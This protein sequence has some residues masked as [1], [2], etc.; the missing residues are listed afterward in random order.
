M[1]EPQAPRALKIDFEDYA[2][3]FAHG[4]YVMSYATQTEVRVRVIRLDDGDGP[5]GWGEVVRRPGS[6]AHALEGAEQACIEALDGRDSG[7]LVEWLRVR[8]SGAE[9]LRGLAFALD[10]ARLDLAARRAQAPLYR[11]LGGRR[12][13]S[14]AEYCSFSGGGDRIEWLAEARG[15]QVVQLKLGIEN[16][17]DDRRRLREALA[18]LGPSQRIM[19]DF[20]GA[21]DV[22][23]A[24]SLI[25]AF[26]DPRLIWEEPCRS[27]EANT[28]VAI[29]SDRPLMFDQCLAD[30]D[31]LLRVVEDGIAH[32]VCIKPAFLG[33]LAPAR[34]ARDRCIEAGMPMR[35]DGPW[36]GHV[37]SAAILHLAVGVPGPLLIA[38][39]DLRQPLRID[40]DWGGIR[41][42]PGKRIAPGDG[43]GHG[44]VPPRF[45]AG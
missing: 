19:A 11:L 40:D 8:P 45:R 44:A 38:G 6:D 15:W 33:G 9:E 36:C 23:E 14:V 21:L 26:D 37:A 5:P 35:I 10:T 24:V 28:R 12:R 22:A 30:L 25:A 7:A 41:H 2:F 42:L 3:P 1:P 16:R 32:S 39:C 20:N 31:T 4:E 13:D 27:V 18:G 34:E 17:G 43:P 29:D